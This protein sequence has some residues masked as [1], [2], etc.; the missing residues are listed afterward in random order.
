MFMLPNLWTFYERPS[1][2]G[3]LLTS[4]VFDRPALQKLS[5][6]SD[7]M[8]QFGLEPARPETARGSSSRQPQV[9]AASAS[10]GFKLAQAYV[11]SKQ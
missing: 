2:R 7:G 5:S 1:I 9:S 3:E 6:C 11:E 8:D 10:G 4:G